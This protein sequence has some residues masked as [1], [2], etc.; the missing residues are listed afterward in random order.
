MRFEWL[1]KSQSYEPLK[2]VGMILP[3]STQ[4]RILRHGT[5]DGWVEGR[6]WKCAPSS[7]TYIRRMYVVPSSTQTLAL[8]SIE[9]P[10][11]WVQATSVNSFMSLRYLVENMRSV[12]R[13]TRRLLGW[14]P[15][16][17]QL[18]LN[19]SNNNDEVK[20]KFWWTNMGSFIEPFDD[21][22]IARVSLNF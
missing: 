19:L 17:K 16:G 9:K 7:S 4:R 15:L 6:N 10:D 3:S 5:S 12:H 21:F 2:L 18:L 11:Q 14:A 1:L 22:R 13:V 20:G 8:V